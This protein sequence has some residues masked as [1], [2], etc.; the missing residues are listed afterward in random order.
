MSLL[1]TEQI[2]GASQPA[3]SPVIRGIYFLLQDVQIVYVG[4][5]SNCHK[6]IHSHMASDEEFNRFAIFSH[7]TTE[8][9]NTV[10]ALHIL[11][12]QPR[13]NLSLPST[14]LLLSAAWFRSNRIPRYRLRRLVAR[15]K[16]QAVHFRDL[17]YYWRAEIEEALSRGE[18]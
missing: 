18:L 2:Y 7:D 14:P 15:E 11:K 3:E 6:R 16:L 8:D 10:E 13:Y 1:T 17:T 5:S 9:L 4:Q 12:Y